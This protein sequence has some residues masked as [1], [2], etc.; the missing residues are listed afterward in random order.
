MAINKEIPNI[1]RIGIIY[2]N[3]IIRERLVLPNESV[4][5]EDKADLGLG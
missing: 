5:V 1:I 4:T 2:D 3:Q